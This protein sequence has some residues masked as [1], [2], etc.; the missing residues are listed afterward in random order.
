[1]IFHLEA[2]AGVSSNILSFS[3]IEVRVCLSKA[4][5]PFKNFVLL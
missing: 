3:L 4:F 1:M 2:D 5:I